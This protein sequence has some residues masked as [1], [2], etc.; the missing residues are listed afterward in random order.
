VYGTGSSTLTETKSP[1]G[2]VFYSVDADGSG[3]AAP[4]EFSNPDF[5]TK[6]LRG[7]AVLRWEF[8]PGSIVY[9]VWT[10]SRYNQTNYDGEFQFGNSVDRLFNTVADNIFLVKFSYWFNI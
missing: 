10:Q 4:I 5:N 6:S 7:N 2:S 3:P 1:D 8:V 9:F